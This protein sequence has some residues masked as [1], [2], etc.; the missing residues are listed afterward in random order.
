MKKSEFIGLLIGLFVFFTSPNV[1][2]RSFQDEASV[3]WLS[4]IYRVDMTVENT[5]PKFEAEV[6]VVGEN[7]YAKKNTIQI[8]DETAETGI[9]SQS[10]IPRN[11]GSCTTIGYIHKING[12]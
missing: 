11:K 9:T 7:P 10:D 8:E 5:Y 4:S 12:P 3:N 1:G 2:A 6:V